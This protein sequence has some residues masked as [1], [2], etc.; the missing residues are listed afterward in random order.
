MIKSNKL[1]RFLLIHL[2]CTI[3]VACA[4]YKPGRVL[5]PQLVDGITCTSEDIC[6][7]DVSRI[8]KASELYRS[9]VEFVTSAVG[10]FE[11][12]PRIVFCS[13]QACFQSFGFN[14]ASAHAVGKSGIIIGPRG[15]T[16]HYVRHEMIHYRQA[17]E[18]GVLNQWLGPKWFIEG[19]AYSLSDDP[20][21]PLSHPWQQYR[22]E[23]DAWYQEIGKEN[24]WREAR[25]L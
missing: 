13:T 25:S 4:A 21:Q 24:L 6:I 20:R 18:L 7:D 15:W 11:K 8:Q 23:F 10:H 16:S 17:E 19:M 1:K 9:A 2:L 3:L 22:A 12:A 14:Q 5:A